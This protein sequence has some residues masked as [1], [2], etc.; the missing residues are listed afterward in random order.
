MFEPSNVFTIGIRFTQMHA[1]RLYLHVYFN[2]FIRG[3][4]TFSKSKCTRNYTGNDVI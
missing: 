1:Y 3:R 2:V 4:V